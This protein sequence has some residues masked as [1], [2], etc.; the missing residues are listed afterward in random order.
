MTY[1][2]DT[3]D[4]LIVT[5]KAKQ[6]ATL[7]VGWSW[8]RTFKVLWERYYPAVEVEYDDLLINLSDEEIDYCRAKGILIDLGI[9][10]F[11]HNGLK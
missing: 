7:K 10:H 9:P 8:N 2:T 1:R 4:E 5:T 11:T 3:I 6:Y